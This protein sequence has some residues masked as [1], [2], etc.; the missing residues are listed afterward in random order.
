MMTDEG[1][2][3]L[4]NNKKEER[5]GRLRAQFGWTKTSNRG[6]G[7]GGMSGLH[8]DVL[9]WKH[10]FEDGRS[11]SGHFVKML[12]LQIQTWHTTWQRRTLT[13][14]TDSV[15]MET[16]GIKHLF[17]NVRVTPHFYGNGGETFCPWRRDSQFRFWWRWYFYFGSLCKK[18]SKLLVCSRRRFNVYNLNVMQ[19]YY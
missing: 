12:H 6:R 2:E 3:E 14:N 17:E 13:D 10:I 11:P 8:D 5:S 1:D 19:F 15:S 4:E 7:G 16:R 18:R 9:M